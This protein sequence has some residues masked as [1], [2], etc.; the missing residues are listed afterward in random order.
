LFIHPDKVFI[1]KI[2]CVDAQIIRNT[3]EIIKL[4]SKKTILNNIKLIDIVEK[5][6]HFIG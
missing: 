5:N 1:K 3:N 6:G 2:N 4:Y